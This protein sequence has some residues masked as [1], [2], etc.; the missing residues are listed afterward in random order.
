MDRQEAESWAARYNERVPPGKDLVYEVEETK[1]GWRVRVRR[2][3]KEAR[4]SLWARWGRNALGTAAGVLFW[5]S[6]IGGC[7]Y[8]MATS[9]SGDSGGAAGGCHPD[10]GDCLDPDAYDYDCEGGSGDGP[11]YTG[12]VDVKGGDP[13]DLDADG[14]GVGCD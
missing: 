3:E 13:F 11:E 12:T 2:P 14:D 4:G 6:L 8:V 1:R 5:G 10:Y 9:D 7:G